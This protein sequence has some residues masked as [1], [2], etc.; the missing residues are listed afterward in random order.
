NDAD[1]RAIVEANVLPSYFPLVEGIILGMLDLQPPGSADTASCD[2][3]S[4]ALVI[5]ARTL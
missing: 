2:A 1:I 4:A 5:D 3:L